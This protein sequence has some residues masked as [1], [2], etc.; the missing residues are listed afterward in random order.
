MN[1]SPQKYNYTLCSEKRNFFELDLGYKT[2]GL[3]FCQL[4]SFRKKV[5]DYTSPSKIYQIIENENFVLMHVADN[6][7]LVYLDIPQLLQL[8]DLILTVFKTKTVFDL[9]LA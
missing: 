1:L 6:K 3:T 9:E 8:K 2:I 5:L 4:L 7:H